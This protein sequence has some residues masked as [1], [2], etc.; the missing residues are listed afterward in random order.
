MIPEQII[1]IISLSGDEDCCE[2]GI[3]L[4]NKPIE[5]N[6]SREREEEEEEGKA[7]EDYII[8]E[9]HYYYYL[10]PCIM[11]QFSSH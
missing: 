6:Y 4:H 7:R 5:R 11:P 10:F 3:R 1:L 2:P 8:N 9:A